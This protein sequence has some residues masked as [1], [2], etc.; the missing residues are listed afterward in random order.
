[1]PYKYV[2]VYRVYLDNLKKRCEDQAEEEDEGFNCDINLVIK[3]GRY[4]I[5]SVIYACLGMFLNRVTTISK[6]I[7][8]AYWRLI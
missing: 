5:Y 3:R 4:D 1:M 2:Y 6:I 8:R 7:Y